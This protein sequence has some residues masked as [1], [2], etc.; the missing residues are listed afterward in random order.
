M[1]EP[2]R[3]PSAGNVVAATGPGLLLMQVG[4]SGAHRNP[5]TLHG[6]QRGCSLES[7]IF[8]MTV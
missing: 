7:F 4:D 2:V 1:A 6:I 5:E 3:I 8:K